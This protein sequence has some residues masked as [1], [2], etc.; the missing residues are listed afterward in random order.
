[1]NQLS[2][3][4]DL[5]RLT[6]QSGYL[7]E[8]EREPLVIVP[9]ATYEKLLSTGQSAEQQAEVWSNVLQE[10]INAW[11]KEQQPTAAVNKTVKSKARAVREERPIH[12]PK[13]DLAEIMTDEVIIEDDEY[14]P[15]PVDEPEN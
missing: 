6:G 2:R 11:Q 10:Q 5:I 8:G 9:L 14:L 13:P 15:E 4:I 7:L 12:Q 1:M 3:I